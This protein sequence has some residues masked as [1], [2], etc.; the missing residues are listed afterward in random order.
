MNSKELELSFRNPGIDYRPVPFWAWN[1]AL[2]QDELDRQIDGFKEQGMGGFMMHV[3]EGLETPYMSDEFLDR[4]KDSVAKAKKAGIKAWLYDEDRYSSGMGGGMVPKAG[5]DAVRSKALT[6]DVCNEYIQDESILAVYRATIEG[7]S[8]TS[9]DRIM[10]YDRAELLSGKDEVYLVFRLRIA[11][12]NDWSH[13]DTYTDLMNSEATRLF[14]DTSYEPYRAAIGEEFGKTVQGIFTDEPTIKGFSER[15]NEPQLTWISWSQVIE[16]AFEKKRGYPIWE[17]LP[18][19]FFHGELSAQIR[20]DYWLTVTELFSESYTKQVS[21]WCREHGIQFTGHFHSESSLLGS[22]LNS[23]AVMPHYR[24]LD[25]PGIDTLCEQTGEHLT[26]KQVS[27]VANQLGKKR[28]ITET[29]GVTGWDLTFENRRWIGDWQFALGVNLLTHHLSWYSLRGC[30]KRDYPPSFNY[31]SNWWEHNR[32]MED[33]Y[34]RLS[35]VLSEGKL[36]RNVLVIHPSTTVWTKLGQSV[37]A[38]RWKNGAGNEQ[39]LIEYDSNFNRFINRLV[40][41]HIDY[42]LGDE[43]LIKEFGKSEADRFIIGQ[44]QYSLVILPSL[45][46]LMYSTLELLIAY[47]DGGGKVAAFGEMPYLLDGKCSE[48]LNDMLLHKAFIRLAD[49]DELELLLDSSTPRAVSIKGQSGKEAQ[50][51]LH[52]HRQM[53]GYAVAFIVN[54]DRDNQCEVQIHVDGGKYLEEWDA[55][56]GKVKRRT[57][58]TNGK[59][60]IFSETFSPAESKLYVVRS[61]AEDINSSDEQKAEAE[62]TVAL[63]P[64]AFERSSPNALVLDQCQ[65]RFGEEQWSQPMEVWRAQRI[66]RERLSMR[67]VYHTGNLQRYFWINDP[68]PGNGTP[69]SIRFTFEAFDLPQSDLYFVFE[70]AER[71][72]FELN[73]VQLEVKPDGFYLDRS[74]RTLKLTGLREGLNT[75]D[76]LITYMNDMEL[77]NGYLIGD[78]AVDE[79]RRLV[80]EPKNLTYGDWRDQ[81]YPHYCGSMNYYFEIEK[82]Q[83]SYN[84]SKLELG[85]YEAVLLDVKVNDSASKTIPWRSEAFV[86]LDDFLK[87]G[88]NKLIIE[89]AGSPRNLFGPL[90]Q[91][92]SN[93]NWLDWWSFHPEDEDYTKDYRGTP[94]GLM[95]PVRITYFK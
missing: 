11:A 91:K 12:K 14:I 63:M 77:E 4:V 36:T 21:D 80:V 73:G 52:M 82:E 66:I 54:N 92:D 75:L 44:A 72:M 64:V 51:F 40:E 31:H 86:L 8:L 50:S 88:L 17:L 37:K 2:K 62:H 81:G 47:M 10:M 61:D 56:T 58:Q 93:P 76:V 49:A 5:G 32:G 18:Y 25:I 79:K 27:S 30:R 59:G 65:Y 46:N 24:Y 13:G 41:Q 87:P 43:L 28:V 7:D 38:E 16:Q 68:H 3:R 20:Y 9:L 94:Y 53:E 57:V 6:L 39:E 23:G 95:E 84:V 42:D 22:T 1:D 15:L 74:M 48:R 45:N 55:W 90:H 34:G 19:I 29:Y 33:Y 85:R 83:G 78:F 89:V 67:Q 71:F 70:D 60:V 69:V 35:V 26:L